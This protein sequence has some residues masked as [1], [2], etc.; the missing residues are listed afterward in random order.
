M[1]PTVVLSVILVIAII[2]A[3]SFGVTPGEWIGIKPA[4]H[5]LPDSVAGI[6]LFVCPASDVVFDE[7]ARG[8]VM[9]R[10]ALTMIFFFF[11]MVLLVTTGWAFYQ[12]LISDKFDKKKYEFPFFLGKALFWATIIFTI[13]LHTPNHFRAVG[14]RGAPGKFVLCESSTPG[15][16]PVR[17][18]AII[19]RSKIIP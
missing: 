7:I 17:A 14:V 9:F 4:V 15:S 1:R 13:L 12:N 18:D 8:L 5:N 6:A 16:R 11:F 3:A 2:I 19:F 10:T